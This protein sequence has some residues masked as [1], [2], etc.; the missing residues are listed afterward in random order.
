M[1]GDFCRQSSVSPTG[2]IR[3]GTG[4]HVMWMDRWTDGPHIFDSF[5]ASADLR[6]AF[7]LRVLYKTSQAINHRLPDSIVSL[8]L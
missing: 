7:C 1:I 2:G 4:F 8:H 5:D 6:C 3:T